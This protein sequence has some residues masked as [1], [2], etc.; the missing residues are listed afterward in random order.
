MFNINK[1]SFLKAVNPQIAVI[2][3]GE[4]N[5]YG[6]PDNSTLF[7]IHQLVKEVYRTDKNG[8][9]IIQSNG[10]NF[11]ADKMPVTFQRTERVAP[12]YEFIGN[13]K[14]KTFH[15]ATCSFVPFKENQIGFHSCNEALKSG[16]KRCKKCNPQ[17]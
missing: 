8:T 3:V 9:I 10:K 5:I 7:R 11:N 2:S 17:D 13:F 15:Y 12:G 4:Q 1:S 16:Y 6:H 14:S